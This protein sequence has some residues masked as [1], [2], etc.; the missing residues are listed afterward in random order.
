MK[1]YVPLIIFILLALLCMGFSCAAAYLLVGVAY[2]LLVAA[3][4]CAGGAYILFRG[5]NAG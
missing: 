5:L 2:A 1:A 3:G 4:F